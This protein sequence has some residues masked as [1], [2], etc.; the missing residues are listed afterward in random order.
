MKKVS[1]YISVRALGCYE[2]KILIPF[3]NQNIRKDSIRFGKKWWSCLVT[4]MGH[5]RTTMAT[6][7]AWMPSGIS[8]NV[9]KNTRRPGTPNFWPTSQTLPWSNSCVQVFRGHIM[10]KQIPELA[11]LSGLGSWNWKTNDLQEGLW[12]LFLFLEKFQIL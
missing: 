12:L 10:K 8:G 9:C 3:W 6:T 2:K 1:G 7:N 5:S 11:R 4:N